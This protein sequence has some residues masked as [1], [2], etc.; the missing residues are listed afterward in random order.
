MKSEN[1]IREIH[2]IRKTFN[3]IIKK[4]KLCWHNDP[5]LWSGYNA[6]LSCKFS[7]LCEKLNCI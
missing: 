6:C 1:H 3:K 7:K 5:V 2:E 4:E